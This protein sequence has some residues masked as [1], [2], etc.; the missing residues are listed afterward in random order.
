MSTPDT[1]TL[2][3][4]HFEDAAVRGE[5]VRLGP[6]LREILGQHFYPVPVAALLGETLAASVLL[7]S[8]IK[9]SGSLSLQ[10]KSEGALGILFGECTHDRQI[11]GYARV[12]EGAV[13]GGL[14]ELLARGTLAITIT[15]EQGQR[16]QGIV[17]L[18]APRLAGCLEHYF[19]QSEQ[20]PTALWLAC[21]GT[22]AAG[23]M[24]QALPRAAGAAVE[25]A[26]R[27]E[28]LHQLAR[29][30]SDAELL[31]EHFET[32]L[33][34]LFH[35]ERVRVHAPAAVRF[36]CRCS[37]RRAANT[38]ESLGEAETRALLAEQGTIR[39]H[40]EFCQQEYRFDAA[41][42]DAMFSAPAPAVTH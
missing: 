31:G 20:L 12:A 39:I 36:G 18:D 4:F 37:A 15:P 27:W 8:T 1:D 29:T 9:Y 22:H 5:L 38:L 14:G 11:R 13:G 10:A 30:V 34:H 23:L 17:P 3:R 25:E 35:Q 2:Q 26:A 21:D 40:C 28:H 32:L 41:A 7:S 19:A 33:F 24:L 6:S 16:Y 42:V